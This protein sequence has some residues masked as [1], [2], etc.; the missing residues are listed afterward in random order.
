MNTRPVR[1]ERKISGG[2]QLVTASRREWRLLPNNMHM[3]EKC[4]EKRTNSI[5]FSTKNEF[6]TNHGRLPYID[7]KISTHKDC[8]Y[9]KKN[10]VTHYSKMKLYEN[11]SKDSC[12]EL[13]L[14]ISKEAL[15]EE[16]ADEVV[17]YLPRGYFDFRTARDWISHSICCLALKN[18]QPCRRIKRR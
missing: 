9:K 2:S 1:P 18:P 15:L 10:D 17:V 16:S 13:L 4:G 7:S 5:E 8:D 12:R 11:R 14:K 6:C 3:L